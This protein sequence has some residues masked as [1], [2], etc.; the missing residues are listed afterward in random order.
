VN[1]LVVGL[2]LVTRR[3]VHAGDRET[4]EWHDKGHNGD[5]TLVCREC[6]EGTDLPGGPRVVALVPKGRKCGARRAHFAHPPGMAPPDG[7]HSPETLWHAEG[8]QQ[9]RRWAQ[10]QGATA[11]VE[12]WTGDGRRRSDVAV[13]LPGGGRMALEVQLGEITD[14][15][16]LDRHDDYAQAGITDVWLWHPGTWIPRVIFDRSQAGWLLDVAAGKIGL[17]YHRAS[18]APVSTPGE[19]TP[20][21]SVHWPPCPADPL[22][23]LWMPLASAQLAPK[24]IKPSADA[25][26]SL[27]CLAEAAVLRNKA[28]KQARPPAGRRPRDYPPR[29]VVALPTPR[30]PDGGQHTKQAPAWHLAVRYD[31]FPPWTDPDTWWYYCDACGRDRITGAELRSSRIVHIA[32]TTKPSSIGRLEVIC[33]QYGGGSPQ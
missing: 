14:A 33:T 31:A 11:R 7:P 13:T 4:W 18:Q 2:D 8:K 28:T 17:I 24:G 26:A 22:D 32:G 3:E 23:T 29:P 27:A 21:R 15:E 10:G 30:T 12:A 20:C 6:Y 19:P 9:L 5:R 25:A 16:W 1:L